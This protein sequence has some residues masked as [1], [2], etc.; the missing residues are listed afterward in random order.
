MRV[1]YSYSHEPA[2]GSDRRLLVTV[3]ALRMDGLTKSDDDS[4]AGARSA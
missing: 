4:E 2:D 3:L 1:S